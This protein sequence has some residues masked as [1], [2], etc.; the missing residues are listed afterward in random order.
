MDQRQVPRNHLRTNQHSNP[1]GKRNGRAKGNE[2]RLRVFYH[3][4]GI[5][6][7]LRLCNLTGFR[8]LAG[9]CRALAYRGQNDSKHAC[10]NN[11][12]EGLLP[13][14]IQPSNKEELYVSSAKAR[15]PKHMIHYK[16][17]QKNGYGNNKGPHKRLNK[18]CQSIVH[19]K[20]ASYAN[21]GKSY[22]NGCHYG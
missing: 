16:R 13:T 5:R 3:L 18:Q 1:T 14:K 19:S 7:H 12:E 11:K 10:Q 20:R 2:S 6:V 17:Q 4:A 8:I 15:S 21:V 22:N 9:V